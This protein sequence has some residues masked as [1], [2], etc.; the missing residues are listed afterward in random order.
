MLNLGHIKRRIAD[1]AKWDETSFYNLE[2]LLNSKSQAEQ[3]ALME[4]VTAY[5]RGKELDAAEFLRAFQ[6]YIA[7]AHLALVSFNTIEKKTAE[8]L[9]PQYM[10]KG[11]ITILAGEGGSGKTTV[12]CSI[13][14]ALSAGRMP[15]FVQ[16]EMLPREWS[17]IPPQKVIVFSGEDSAEYVLKERLEKNGADCGNI[18][19][20]PQSSED[21][22]NVTFSGRYIERVIQSEHPDLCIFDPIQ[23]FVPDNIDMGKRNAIRQCLQPLA[24]YGEKYGTTF[25][26]VVHA[27]KQSG[28]W[29]RR[30]MADSSDI[31]DI[32]RS[33]LML[34]EVAEGK[35]RYI[36]QEKSNYGVKGRSALFAIDDG[37]VRFC[38]YSDKRDREFVQEQSNFN[39]ISPALDTAEDFI[40]EYLQDG[41]EHL[42]SDLD[43]AAQVD[44]I[45]PASLKRAK[46][47]LKQDGEIVYH[48][49]GFGVDKKFYVALNPSIA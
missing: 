10:P 3:T 30:R 6:E 47:N 38:G 8:F 14:A 19:T 37:A 9:V 41:K 44:G 16:P 25:L 32:A 45:S 42:V 18:L 4:D 2:H 43:T 21:F 35:T 7:E 29:G 24:G 33:V 28:V 11:A 40:L 17:N 26:L 31:W 36:S 49:S 12:W 23:S 20:I 27:N 46:N 34:G 22:L 13:A 1:P 15:F 48:S 39:R 5:L